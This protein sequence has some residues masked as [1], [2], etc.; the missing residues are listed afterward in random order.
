MSFTFH[1][2]LVELTLGL[3]LRSIQELTSLFLV[4]ALIIFSLKLVAVIVHSLRKEQTLS[5]RLDEIIIKSLFNTMFLVS[6]TIVTAALGAT[7]SLPVL[8]H[9]SLWILVAEV[10]QIVCGLLKRVEILASWELFGISIEITLILGQLI[11][12]A[13]VDAYDFL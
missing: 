2:N 8:C 9:I 6:F 1:Y 5:G 7:I 13:G 4:Y 11:R 10:N 3:T 12:L